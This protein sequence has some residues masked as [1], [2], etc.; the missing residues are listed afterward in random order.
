MLIKSELGKQN[1]MTG[2]PWIKQRCEEIVEFVK[3]RGLIDVQLKF[4]LDYGWVLS[5]TGID[6]DGTPKLWKVCSECGIGWG[7][8]G[9]DWHQVS[10]IRF[11]NPGEV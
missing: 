8:K 1:E 6:T 3:S 10:I 4:S 5:G 9:V 2:G 11:E 7:S